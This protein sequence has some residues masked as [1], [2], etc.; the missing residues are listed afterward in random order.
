MLF[1]VCAHGAATAAAHGRST[2]HCPRHGHVG[3]WI[4]LFGSGDDFPFPALE[5]TNFQFLVNGLHFGLSDRVRISD[6]P[7][8]RTT[9]YGCMKTGLAGGM[10]GVIFRCPPK[11]GLSTKR[12]RGRS[13]AS[14][15]QSSCR[16]NNDKGLGTDGTHFFGS[17]LF[18]KRSAAA[19]LFGNVGL[20]ILDDA[21]RAAAQQDVLT[22]GIAGVVSRSRSRFSVPAESNGWENPQNNPR[23]GA[24][25]EVRFVWASSSGGRHPLGRCGNGRYDP[26]GSTGRRGFRADQRISA[27]EM[28]GEIG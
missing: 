1:P 22:Y 17:L 2:T 19:F 13:S 3:A 7:A 24:R 21:V 28:S 16:I 8:S 6:R 26:P 10:I 15:R 23:P 12:A 20:G 4:W 5:A 14:G 25:T 18:G 11:S 9:F 27:L